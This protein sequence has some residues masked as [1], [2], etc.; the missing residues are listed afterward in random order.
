[1]A[2]WSETVISEEFSS[3]K[4]FLEKSEFIGNIE[5]ALHKP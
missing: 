3:S 5:P 4:K 2:F 1:M